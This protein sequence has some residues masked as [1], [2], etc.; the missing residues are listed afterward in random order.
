LVLAGH[1]VKSRSYA[2]DSCWYRALWSAA[3]RTAVKSRSDALDSCS[4]VKG[5]DAG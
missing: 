3:A 4:G 2:L 1:P 5:D